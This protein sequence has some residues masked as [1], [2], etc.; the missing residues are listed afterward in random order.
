[1][2]NTPPAGQSG[3]SVSVASP[4]RLSFMA[5]GGSPAFRLRAVCIVLFCGTLLL[6]SRAVTHDFLDLDDPDYVTENVHVQA[7]LTWAGLRWAFNSGDAANW[8]PLTRLSHMLDWQL[9]GNHPHGHHAINVLWHA[10]SAVMAFLAL[11]RLTGLRSNESPISSSSSP[12]L[13]TGSKT[14]AETASARQA[15]AFWTSAVCAALFAWHPLRVESV[16]WV[17][18]RKDVLSVFFG[19]LALWAYAGYVT[20]RKRT[21]NIEHRTP[22][23]ECEGDANIRHPMPE[24]AGHTSRYYWLALLSFALGLMCKPMLVT[25]PFLLLLLDW[26]PLGRFTFHV[27]RFTMTRSLVE[28]IPFFLLTIASCIVTYLVQKNGGAVTD[29]F[30]LNVRLANAAVSVARYLGM[31]FWPFNLAVGYSLPD[32]W[33]VLTVAGACLLILA[34]T[35][36]A[37][38]QRHRRPWLL[39]GW[40][41]FLGMLV[42]VI[43]LVQVGLQA[44]ADRYTYLPILGVQ[45]ALLWTL[46]DLMQRPVWQ[47]LMPVAIVLVLAGSAA[48]TWNQLAVWQNPH[49]LHEHALAVTRRN[50][51]AES[52]LGT[53]F[54][55]ENRY[56]EAV[57]HFRRAIEFKPDYLAARYRL[58]VALEKMGQTDEAMATY[59][60]LLKI[61]PWYGVA[62]YNLGGL[63]LERN[64]PA[65]AIPHFQ[66]A[67]KGKP[68]YDPAY[69]ALGAA[70]SKLNR[71]QEA[72]HYYEQALAIN[73]RN[74]VAHFDYA[75]ALVDLHREPEALARY[76]KA[77]QLDPDFEE[78]HCNYANALRALNRLDDACVHYRRAIDLQ[79]KN[80]GAFFG[81]G[82]ALED[83]GH[84][85]EALNCYR[86][87]AQL[88]PDYADAQYNIGAILLNRNEAAEAIPYFQAAV[89]SQ[90]DYATAY[91]GLGLAAAQLGNPQEAIGHYERALAIAPDNVMALCGIGV[92]LRRQDQFTE[93][94]P[95]FEKALQVKPDY[96]EAHA[97]LGLALYRTGHPAE[98]IPHLEQALKLQPDFPE[99]A[100]TLAK[101]RGEMPADNTGNKP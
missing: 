44:I 28:K 71:P 30:P 53:T 87:A 36:L 58:G 6:Y 101:A 25:L 2:M 3:D 35:G 22:S 7:G 39:V 90:P 15:G 46:R 20:G 89:K 51:L 27:S 12:Q 61:R 63:L 21:S 29:T 70:M 24:M 82:A 45:I 11:R 72:I 93:A 59:T 75:N 80:A 55:N 23:V 81:L 99:A 64:L 50:Y 37:V 68:D 83:L 86:K 4:N 88:E 1:M 73:P 77:L 57:A 79:P 54:M 17:A 96:A 40:L 67:L 48:R 49:T 84:S 65:E 13:D 52:Y 60:E 47:W 98:A 34:V 85:D 97:G 56:A 9:F 38:W 42:P 19:L 31:F 74:A 62:H 10:L 66:T 18:E 69:L 78:A 33:P 91:L 14:I 8:F 5:W 26:W 95:Y 76:E 92:A 41:W 16:A 100:E 94:I 32:H 43:G